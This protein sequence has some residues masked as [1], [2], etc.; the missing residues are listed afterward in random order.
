MMFAEYPFM[1]R[2][3]R[4]KAAGF[5]AVEF[6]GWE[7]K[8]LPAIGAAA[9]A[10]GV[11]VSACC[12]GTRDASRA[13]RYKKGAMLIRENASFYADMVEESMEAAAPAGIRTLIATTGQA[14]EGVSRQ[15]QQDAVVECLRAAAPVLAKCGFTLVL[16]PLNVLVNHKGYYLDTSKQAFDIL[17]A[18]GSPNAR[19]LYD[20][21]HQ[22]ITEGNLIQT[23]SENIDLIGHF[24]LADVPGRHEPGSGEINYRNVLAA[25]NA[26]GY[27]GYVGCEYAPSE[28]LTTAESARELLDIT[29]MLNK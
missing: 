15:K 12:V 25:I 3:K 26:T 18:V 20:I 4:A 17:R 13:E 29:K 8:D 19:L 27:K 14:L 1:D 9:R 23:I 10:A 28:G 22:Q 21:Y 11:A 7:N 16:E 24:H 2:I 5:S 6:W